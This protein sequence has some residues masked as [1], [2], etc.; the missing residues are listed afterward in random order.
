MNKSEQREVSKILS[1]SANLGGDWAARAISALIR[2][3]MRNK[4]KDQMIAIAQ[5]HG[6]NK[7]LEFII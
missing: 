4:A 1:W 6:W 3:S 7:S 2:A 5:A